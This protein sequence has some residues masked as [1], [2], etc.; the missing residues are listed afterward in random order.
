MCHLTTLSTLKPGRN[1]ESTLVV[2]EGGSASGDD[3]LVPEVVTGVA[4]N[5]GGGGG[6]LTPEIKTDVAGGGSGGSGGLVPEVVTQI[7]GGGTGR[8]DPLPTP[9]PSETHYDPSQDE[10]VTNNIDVGEVTNTI[11]P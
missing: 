3:G 8:N 9:D 10:V 11:D 4:G 6:G 1:P 7:S 5:G 2:V